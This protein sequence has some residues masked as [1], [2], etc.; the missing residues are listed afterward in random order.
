MTTNHKIALIG[1][2]GKAGKYILKNLIHQGFQV[3]ALVRSPEKIQ[4]DSPLVE[5]VQGD[6]RDIS[7][8]QQLLNGCEAVISALGQPAGQP[9]VFSEATRHIITVMTELGLKR[10]LLITGLNVDT[11]FDQKS[12]K[13]QMGTDWMKANYP[14][15]TADKQLEYETLVK[16]ELDWTLVRLPMI[17]QTDT[18][19][20]IKVDLQDCPG[21]QISATALANFLIAQLKEQSYSRQAPFIANV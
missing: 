7:A 21:D 8:V 17:E 4:F 2:S 9:S 16:S 18:N 1:G 12:Q 11:P 10:Y 6:V 14:V 20:E 19:N 5:W 15:T 3:K 13:T